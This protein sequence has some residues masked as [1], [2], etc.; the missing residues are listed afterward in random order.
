MGRSQPTVG[1][2]DGWID[3]RRF[4]LAWTCSWPQAG[5]LAVCALSVQCGPGNSGQDIIGFEIEIEV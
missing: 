3:G 1:P 2:G 5:C 4:L